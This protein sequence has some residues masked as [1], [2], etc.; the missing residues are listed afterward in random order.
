MQSLQEKL[1][2]FEAFYRL[3][4]HELVLYSVALTVT[5]RVAIYFVIWSQDR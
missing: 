5:S 1:S 4:Y 3:S 2:S